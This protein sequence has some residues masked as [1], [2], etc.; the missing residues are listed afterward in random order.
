MA[1]KKLPPSS[2]FRSF[3]D[4]SLDLYSSSLEKDFDSEFLWS[5]DSN[6]DLQSIEEGKDL[7]DEVEIDEYAL[8]DEEDSH[9]RENCIVTILSENLS[10]PL[11]NSHLLQDL[12][13]NGVSNNSSDSMSLS[14]SFHTQDK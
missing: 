9:D 1:N 5:G 7:E 14:D 3:H 12:E 4:E 11:H 6:D 2:E 10:Y 8:S 13:N